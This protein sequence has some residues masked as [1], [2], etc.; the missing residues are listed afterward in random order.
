MN[1]ITKQLLTMVSDY[2]DSKGYADAYSI[3]E[4]GSCV[5]RRS[6]EH[7]QID[8]KEDNPGTSSAFSPA[9]RA[10]ACPSPRA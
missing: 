7:I 1:E 9:H 3:R 6:T 5:E 2:D 8:S 4:N 10:S